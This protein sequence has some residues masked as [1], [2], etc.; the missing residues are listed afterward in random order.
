MKKKERVTLTHMRTRLAE[1]CK[2][3][4]HL[5]RH[6]HHEFL[7]AERRGDDRSAAYYSATRLQARFAAVRIYDLYLEAQGF[8]FKAHVLK[9]NDRDMRRMNQPQQDTEG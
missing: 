1:A 9:Q 7:R 6:Y 2:S 8:G 5:L 4:F 3:Q